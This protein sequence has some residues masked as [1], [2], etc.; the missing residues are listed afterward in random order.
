MAAL[1]R[2]W[3]VPEEAILLESESGTT[4]E[5]AL[6]NRGLL[7]AHGLKRVLLVTSAWHMPRALA[8]FRSAGIH[9]LPSPIQGGI[10]VF[11]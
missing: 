1:W 5:N 6:Y 3:G 4:Y 8:T 11:T 7:E 2:A 9:A 10:L